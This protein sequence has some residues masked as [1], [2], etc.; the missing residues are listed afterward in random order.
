MRSQAYEITFKGKAG[1]TIRAEFNDCTVTVGSYTTTLHAELPDQA[2][3]AGLVPSVQ[4][5]KA[6]RAI[7]K[8]GRA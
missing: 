2:A 5:G 1:T 6:D 7:A 8:G 4:P 3:L